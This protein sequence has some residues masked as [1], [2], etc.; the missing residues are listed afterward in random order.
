VAE[1]KQ[2][3]GEAK[4]EPVKKKG[5]PPIVLIAVGAIVGGAGAVFAIP[6]KTVEVKVEPKKHI[7]LD[8]LHPDP[9]LHEFNPRTKAGKGM[10]R[11]SFKFRYSVRDD[12]EDQAFEQLKTRWEEA[13]S[14]TLLLLKQR[15]MEELQ[16]DAGIQVLKKDLVEN[17]DQQLFPAGK[18]KVAKIT[19]VL[20]D[21]WLMQ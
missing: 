4:A 11:V 13:K 15:S 16:T 14:S 17:L 9:I 5:L 8:L 10:V 12:Q 6:P 7:Q 20:F 19:N 21:K 3:N 18:D 2:K 1:D